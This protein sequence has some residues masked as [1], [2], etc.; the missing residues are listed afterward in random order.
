[1]VAKY[2]EVTPTP[3]S[4]TVSYIDMRNGEPMLVTVTR[5]TTAAGTP[6]A[7]TPRT[8]DEA[9]IALL[10][11]LAAASAVGTLVARRRITRTQATVQSDCHRR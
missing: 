6:V 4:K 1:M 2:N 8:S 3:E 11:A 10:A 5:T 9:P 7:T